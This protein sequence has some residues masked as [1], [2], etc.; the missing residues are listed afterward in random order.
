M[1]WQ[2]RRLSDINIVTTGVIG[3]DVILVH[4]DG[5]EAE[6]VSGAEGAKRQC[7]GELAAEYQNCLC[8]H[9]LTE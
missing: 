6:Q 4:V 1:K 2:R 9:C 8:L 5:E 3:S 7:R